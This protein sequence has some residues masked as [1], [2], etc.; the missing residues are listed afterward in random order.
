MKLGVK[1]IDIIQLI[2]AITMLIGGATVLLQ[3]VPMLDKKNKFKPILQFIGRYIAL[4]K[5]LF[6][7]EK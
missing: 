2:E 1:M 3:A 6:Y 7:K 5:P 4:N